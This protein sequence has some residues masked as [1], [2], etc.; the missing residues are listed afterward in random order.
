MQKAQKITLSVRYHLRYTV[1]LSKFKDNFE[2]LHGKLIYFSVAG[3]IIQSFSS[4]LKDNTP[5]IES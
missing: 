2:D 3:K 5:E 1:N 4:A